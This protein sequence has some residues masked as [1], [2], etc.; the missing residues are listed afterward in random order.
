MWTVLAN[1]VVEELPRTSGVVFIHTTLFL[2][3]ILG[4]AV[5]AGVLWRTWGLLGTHLALAKRQ[6]N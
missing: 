2:L 1:V 3:V 5:G 4:L 6:L